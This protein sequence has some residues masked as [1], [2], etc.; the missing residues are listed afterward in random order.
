MVEDASIDYLRVTACSSREA[1]P[2][3]REKPDLSR[4]V[5]TSCYQKPRLQSQ[6]DKKTKGMVSAGGIE[7]TLKRTFNNMQSNGRALS[8]LS[9][10]KAVTMAGEW[11]VRCVPRSLQT[12]LLL[13]TDFL[14]TGDRAS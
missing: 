6:N 7:S 12:T 8:D 10:C 1:F 4:T 11:Q 14:R 9:T 5:V 13:A 3:R 2:T